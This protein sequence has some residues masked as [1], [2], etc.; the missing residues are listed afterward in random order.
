MTICTKATILV[1]LLCL[2][3]ANSK[4]QLNILTAREA[5]RILDRVPAVEE[6]RARGGCPSYSIAD[7]V[8]TNF[9][10]QVRE[11]CLPAGFAS[12]LLDNYVISRKTG[13]VAEGLDAESVGPR[14]VTPE[15]DS[16]M[17]DLIRRARERALTAKEAECLVLEAARSTSSE[18]AGSLSAT[19]LRETRA[20][21]RF[22]V[23][24]RIPNAPGVAVKFFSVRADTARVRDDSTGEPMISPGLA[25]LTSRILSIR[26]QSGLSVDDALAVALKVPALARSVANGCSELVSSG[27]GTSDEMYIGLRSSCAGAPKTIRVVAAVNRSSGHVTDPKTHKSLD[28][29]ESDKIARE[30]LERQRERLDRDRASVA[31]CER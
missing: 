25:L 22:S 21:W 28:A 26:E 29:P 7:A 27:D 16:L 17:S 5:E 9:S 13:A 6:S 20:E 31:E 18:S 11:A 24:R 23:E 10:I 3:A 2:A 4:A 30:I 12:N 1:I 14:I 15:I 8:A 19:K